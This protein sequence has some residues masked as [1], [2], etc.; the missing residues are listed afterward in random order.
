MA[1]VALKSIEMGL[2]SNKM[3]KTDKIKHNYIFPDILSKAMAKL[4]L[5]VQYEAS[6]MSMSLMVLGLITTTI[7]LTFYTTFVLWYKIFL[8]INCL[9][10]IV[11]MLSFLITTFQQYQ[12]YMEVKEFQEQIKEDKIEKI[13]E[14]ETNNNN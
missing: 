1:K 10:G 8:I 3:E 13:N 11:F 6:M 4:P 5:S 7:Y 12:N 2:E 14:D 9:A